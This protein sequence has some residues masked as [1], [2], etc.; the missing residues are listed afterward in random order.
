MTDL[1][2]ATPRHRSRLGVRARLWGT[3]AILALLPIA[4]TVVSW[5]AFE[6]FGRALAD[7][8][9]AKLPQM[10]G[11]LSLARDGDRL[12]LSGAGLAAATT[13][14]MRQAQQ[15]AVAAGV[16]RAE[17]TVARLRA[18]GLSAQSTQSTEAA[19]HRLQESIAQVDRTV[20]ERLD[21][22]AKMTALQQTVLALGDRFS[23]ALEPISAEQRNAMSGFIS[24]LG[25]NADAGRRNEATDG[26]QSVADA[27]RSL[28]RLG[29]ANATLQSTISQIPLAA[30]GAALDRLMQVIRR[31]TAT[32]A[33]AL[34]DLD[35]KS[36]KAITPLVDE[37]D[38][39]GKSNPTNLRR[40]QLELGN[41]SPCWYGDRLTA[42]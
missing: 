3:I 25:G 41:C 12:V 29:A 28:G 39:L 20:G 32:M 11:A 9:D 23:R 36:S 30:D 15:A 6:A 31:D 38:R 21:A 13:A 22:N 27:T 42:W 17:E 8:I 24:T 37:W 2:P 33:S 14:A 40:R 5:R 19:L 35:E 34:D 4:S 10:E 7:V 1:T 16:K 26:L 18:L